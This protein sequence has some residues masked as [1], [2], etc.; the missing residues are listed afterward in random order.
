MYLQ[1]LKRRFPLST[2]FVL[3]RRHGLP[4]KRI[5]LPKQEHCKQMMACKA[6]RGGAVSSEQIEPRY[7]HRKT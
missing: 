3:Q 4:A 1:Q 7:M 2:W 6:R 5:E